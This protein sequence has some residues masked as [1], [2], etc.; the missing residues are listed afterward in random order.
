MLITKVLFAGG[1][2][3][4]HI[5]MA[6]AIAHELRERNPQTE[7]RFVGTKR[8]M[9]KNILPQLGFE[10]Q[11]IDIGGLKN[12]G[13][14]RIA[15]TLLRLPASLVASWK[16]VRSY[17]PTVIVG[18]GGYSSGPVIVAGKLMRFPCLLIEPNVRAGLTNRWLKP[19]V[20]RAAVAFEETA[21][22]FGCKARLTGI[23]IRR[24]FHA[25]REDVSS[26]GP[27]RLLAFGGSQGSH[28][29]NRLLCDALPHLA[30]GRVSIMHQTG[31]S[32]WEWVRQRY[33]EAGFEAEVIE[34]IEDMPARFSRSDLI[35]SRSG[36]S[37]VAEI[38]ASG[39]AALLIPFP[40]AADDH[41]RRNAEALAKRNAALV[42]EEEQTSGLELATTVL[43]LADDRT[44]LRAMAQSS[45]ALAQPESTG[46]VIELMEEI[47]A[48]DY[49]DYRD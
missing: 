12:V 5:Y 4:G 41:Q 32:D 25:I 38:A 33:R 6:V 40:R 31:P 43:Q 7:I 18:L 49:T 10:L 42:L 29:I 9:E 35:I 20:D 44:R 21:R 45:R 26:Q 15:S 22:G 2:T 8:G 1:G 47:A 17:A 16:L 34:F 3:G 13:L 36:A 28:A 48:T 24:E 30:G 27:L 37:S 11:L 14:S 39:R 19:W 46:K 23:P